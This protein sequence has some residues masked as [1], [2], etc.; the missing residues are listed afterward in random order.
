VQV[1]V[2]IGIGIGVGVGVGV[3][4]VGVG[5]GVGAGGSFWGERATI[6]GLEDVRGGEEGNLE[7]KVTCSER[8]S[9]E[10]WTVRVERTRRRVVNEA[11][12]LGGRCWMLGG[13]E[14]NL[15]NKKEI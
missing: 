2:G 14:I 12:I 9:G 5:V 15:F 11:F 6:S 13:Y 1:V 10:A 8:S 7:G 3:G 4:R